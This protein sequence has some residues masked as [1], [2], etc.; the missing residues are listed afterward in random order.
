MILIAVLAIGAAACGS[1]VGDIDPSTDAGQSATTLVDTADSTVSPDNGA[2]P[3][4]TVA[5]PPGVPRA[6]PVKP[7]VEKG[8]FTLSSA[9][10][11]VMESYPIQ[12]TVVVDG[13]IPTPCDSAG[14]KVEIVGDEI[15]VEVYS[16]PLNDP[17]VSCIAQVEDVAVTVPLGS[18]QDGAYTVIVNGETVGSFEA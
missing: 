3:G 16:I 7:P 4:S 9:D 11:L 6:D 10:V 12:V 15:L 17:A 14:W 1:G 13:T 2:A 8:V 18:F 5:E